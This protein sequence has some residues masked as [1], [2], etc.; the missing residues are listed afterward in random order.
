LN[1]VILFDIDC[2]F[3][4]KSKTLKIQ[5]RIDLLVQ[6]GQYIKDGGDAELDLVIRKSTAENPW[7][8]EENV[9]F[10]LQSICSSMLQES[11]LSAW[12]AQYT[13]PESDFPEKSIGL[14]M[15][16][17]LPLVGFHD[18]L[19]VFVAG[20]RAQVKL[21]EKD[22]HLLPFLV[23]KMAEWDFEAWAY[24]EFLKPDERLHGFDAVIATGSNNT[25]RYF[26]QYF[27]KYPHII[28]HNRNGI[29]ILDGQETAE[30]LHA[31]GIDIF[32]YFGL[33]CRNVS[34]LYVPENY[35]FEPLLEA[36]H[37]YNALALHNK[38]INNFDYNFTLYVLNNM[39]Y[40]NNGCLLLREDPS[41]QSRIASVHYEYYTDL[42][43]LN[44]HLASLKDQ[45]QCIV[46]KVVLPDH[47]VLVFGKSQAPSLTD[48]PDGADVMA[49]L[50]GL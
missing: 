3:A 8:T 14:V 9:Q 34:K 6:L 15:A 12:I 37:A 38:Y 30:D 1:F 5:K 17:N 16:G 35:N 47:T 25:A 13:L 39:P 24:T 33:G 19:C 28:R 43:S 27:G 49:F 26:E 20:M 50:C 2:I 44:A 45:I 48:Y 32:A 4:K 22:Q 23:K 42:N 11:D 36:L 41:L 46:G 7:F 21:S 40:M 31:L 18:W 10:A 29:A